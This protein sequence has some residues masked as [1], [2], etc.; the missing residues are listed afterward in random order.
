MK[1]HTQLLTLDLDT[2][3]P[4]RWRLSRVGTVKE[5]GIGRDKEIRSL[6]ERLLGDVGKWEERMKELDEALRCCCWEVE[7]EIGLMGWFILCSSYPVCCTNKTERKRE[8]FW[9]MTIGNWTFFFFGIWWWWWWT[10]KK[11]VVME[12][13][14]LS[15]LRLKDKIRSSVLEDRS[16]KSRENYYSSFFTNRGKSADRSIVVWTPDSLISG[17]LIEWEWEGGVA[18]PPDDWRR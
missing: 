6:E 12:L 14:S 16:P 13:F 1:Y 17:G 11:E 9:G 3:G 4:A 8:L 5:E 7:K 15:L 18:L 2:T 10:E